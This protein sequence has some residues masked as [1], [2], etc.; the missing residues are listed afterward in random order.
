MEIIK[1]NLEIISTKTLKKRLE[2]ELK[3]LILN[4]VVYPESV[5]VTINEPHKNEFEYKVGFF[6]VKNNNY[7]EFL[8]GTNHPFRP[9][10]LNLN[11]RPY[12]YIYYL[13]SKSPGF[14]EKLFK[15]KKI[16]CFCCH[17]KLCSD[18]WSPAYT[19]R[20]IIDEANYFKKICR[21][22]AI[23]ITVDV[24]KRKYL[25]SDINIIQWVY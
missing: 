11:F 18:N 13:N 15:Y 10:K 14:N 8:F 19:M 16:R 24:I 22:I 5:T 7:Y 20:H 3:E 4:N 23:H 25:I 2:H 6:V 1:E 12:S 21:E 9:P 17:T